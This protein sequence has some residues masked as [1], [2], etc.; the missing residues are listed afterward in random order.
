MTNAVRRRNPKS[1]WPLSAR[2]RHS[3]THDKASTLSTAEPASSFGSNQ[4]NRSSSQQR[5]GLNRRFTPFILC[6]TVAAIFTAGCAHHPPVRPAPQNPTFRFSAD[7]FDYANELAWEYDLDPE[8]DRITTHRREPPPDYTLH[9]FPMVHFARAF[10]YHARFAPI[11]PKVSDEEYRRRVS[12]L[13]DL[14]ERP[15]PPSERILIPGFPTLRTF[16]REHEDLLKDLCGGAWRSYLQKGNWRMIFPFTRSHQRRIAR[17]LRAE[18]R[19]GRL[20]I[21]HLV[22]FPELSINHALLLYDFELTPDMIRFSAYDPNCPD[23]PSVLL[24]RRGSR[25]FAFPSNLY[26]R[27]GPVDVYEV[28]HA[29]N[30]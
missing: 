29:W 17:Q 9:C 21:V 28:Y 8:T 15:S 18:L 5:A 4:V 26:F 24:F 30:Y 19:A 10:Y 13:L 27:G 23:Q 1:L 12:Q 25:T 14:A 22:T 2:E 20:P 16:S 3:A 11:A 6:L 7:T